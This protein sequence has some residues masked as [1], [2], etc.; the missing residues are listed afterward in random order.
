MRSL[1]A[2]FAILFIG[3]SCPAAAGRLTV[4]ESIEMVRIIDPGYGRR[5]EWSPDGSRFY[6]TTR[7]GDLE[8]GENQ[9]DVYVVDARVI[10]R[11]LRNDSQKL[12]KLLPLASFRTRS[13]FVIPQME[14]LEGGDKLA[15]IAQRGDGPPQIYILDSVSG[16]EQQLTHSSD[17]II[18]FSLRGR[19]LIYSA[20][21]LSSEQPSPHG[22]AISHQS[23]RWTAASE[24]HLFRQDLR[25]N[26]VSEL[27]TDGLA[28]DFP[29]I[30]SPSG[31][32]IAYKE[33][34][35]SPPEAWTKFPTMQAL[36][37]RFPGLYIASNGK[38]TERD[39]FSGRSGLVSRAVIANVLTGRRFY[40]DAP[41]KS[42]VVGALFDAHWDDSE[43]NVVVS[44][45]ETPAEVSHTGSEPEGDYSLRVDLDE[46]R[47]ARVEKQ[48]DQEQV[49]PPLLEASVRQDMNTPPDIFVRLP[50]RPGAQR[51][52]QL[53]P[54]LEPKL[55]KVREFTFLDPYGTKVR[56]G[57]TLP[58]DFKTGHKYPAVIQVFGFYPDHFTVDGMYSSGFAA[59]ALATQGIV[60]VSLLCEESGFNGRGPSV[61]TGV[62]LN[63]TVMACYEA[64]IRDLVRQ[65]L[66]DPTR[67]GIT[68]FS[69][70]GQHVMYSLAFSSFEFRAASISDAV[71]PTPGVYAYAYGS[72]P[73]GVTEF[74]ENPAVAHPMIGAQF[75]GSGV[76]KWLERSPVY[77]LDR[78]RTPIR[79]EMIGDSPG[80][81]SP[82]FEIY[83]FL[84]RADRPIELFRIP[85]DSHNVRTPW[86]MYASQQGLVDWFAYWLMDK[87][88]AEPDASAGET[89]ETLELQY[90]RWDRMREERDILLKKPRAAVRAWTGQFRSN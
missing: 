53:N 82:I 2:A 39:W 78:V 64:A 23:A 84:R 35:D 56:G 85:N 50:G 81:I 51:L 12:P 74:D 11:A 70:T 4:R 49:G 43:R 77:Q 41:I 90:T 88:R 13:P 68:G 83:S 18:S 44:G 65:G 37:G 32:W 47:I 26:V 20:Q 22:F 38:L 29:P 21:R 54:Q 75:I 59:Q 15:L 7:K 30:I 66:V 63:P 36:T 42:G 45:T 33:R 87:K 46:G 89:R 57:L 52:T 34:V 6:F 62:P 71:I 28:T 55:S 19:T 79:A 80:S 69:G 5:V 76:D 1:V 16:K 10:S 67:V 9:I 73:Y 48:V 72:R 8:T 27:R 61:G 60:V 14:W 17:D 24:L 31:L 86:G 58:S 25:S 40:I 3:L